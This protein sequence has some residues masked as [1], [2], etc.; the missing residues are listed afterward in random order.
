MSGG[1]SE[2]SRLG[3]GSYPAQGA[4]LRTL[5]IPEPSH[6]SALT[7]K[8]ERLRPPV[9]EPDHPTTVRLR[10]SALLPADSPRLDGENDDHIQVLAELAEQALPPVVVD[11]GTMRVIDGM[12]RLRA[13]EL[14]GQDTVQVRFY[15]GDEDDAFVLAVQC[16]NNHGLPLSLADRTAAAARIVGS[17]PD[18]SDR[19][20]A[21]V[22]GLSAATVRAVRMRS[23]DDSAQSNTRLGRDGRRRPINSAASRILA[24]RL[25]Q[26]NPDTP[27][28]QIADAANISP[29][30]ALDVRDR[31]RDGRDPV[32]SKLREGHFGQ[33]RP[34][35]PARAQR[36]GVDW[37][38]AL[39]QVRADPS[40]RF[41]DTGRVLLRLFAPQL[42]NAEERTRLAEGVPTHCTTSMACLARLTAE[43][44]RELAAILEQRGK[45]AFGS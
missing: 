42:L 35:A 11:R 14:R 18:W 43:A 36:T 9:G 10:I 27:L 23:T 17:H 2:G 31:L 16:N 29:S 44:W 33:S 28:R 34:P 7:R 24:S 41:T 3:Q 37:E 21:E 20:I 32:P 12:H 26:E 45:D 15:D 22:V 38:A 5:G 39:H 1:R 8:V 25:I 13:C 19:R 30:T 6:V 40:L 4:Q